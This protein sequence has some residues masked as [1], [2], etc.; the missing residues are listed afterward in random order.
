M[1]VF[2]GQKPRCVLEIREQGD[3]RLARILDLIR[4]C[5]I[6][7]HDLSRVSTPVRFNMP[8]ELG[9]ACALKLLHPLE[10]EVLV[11]DTTPYRLDKTLS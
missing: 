4:A 9:I 2:L 6:S 11:L 7:V 8:F 5:R 1:L 3:G 10:Y